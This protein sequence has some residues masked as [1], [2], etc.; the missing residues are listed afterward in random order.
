[1]AESG[2]LWILDGES[3]GSTPW[4]WTAITEGGS[5]TFALDAGAK[6]NGSYGYK[7]TANASDDAYGRKAITAVD[8]IYVRFYLFIPTGF[9]VGSGGG[10]SCFIAMF[11]AVLGDEV[12]FGIGSSIAAGEPTAWNLW[13]NYTNNTSTTNFSLNAWHYIEIRYLK[14]ASTGGG[15][16]WVDGT[17]IVSDLDQAIAA[18]ATQFY[19]GCQYQTSD[20]GAGDYLYFDDIKADTSQVGAYADAGGAAIRILPES[21]GLRALGGLH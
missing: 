1:M 18:Q 12:R 5:A 13:V 15:E 20:I 17:K 3:A 4:E 8:E 19:L 14:H 9:N 10:E 2:G 11:N 16:C 6:N 7:F 21:L